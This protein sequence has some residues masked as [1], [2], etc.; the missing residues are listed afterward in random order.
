MTC[1]YCNKPI[2]DGET[3]RCPHCFAAIEIAE[4][5]PE[6]AENEEG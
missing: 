4:V 2:P 6:T 3:E 1:K 5:Q